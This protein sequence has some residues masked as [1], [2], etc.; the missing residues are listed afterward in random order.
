ML[1]EDKGGS[2]K[3]REKAV[4]IVSRVT[5]L[6]FE[7][8]CVTGMNETQSWLKYVAYK[9]PMRFANELNI[10]LERK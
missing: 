7:L 1:Q 6:E 9:E 3:I 10:G 4:A 2:R 8:F 5:W